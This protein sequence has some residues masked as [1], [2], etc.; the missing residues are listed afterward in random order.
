MPAISA[1]FWLPQVTTNTCLDVL[2][3]SWSNKP[4]FK[5]RS[6]STDTCLD[7]LDVPQL[8]LHLAAVSPA[9]CTIR[10]QNHALVAMP[11]L[12][13]PM[14]PA[15][16]SQVHSASEHPPSWRRKVLC[17]WSLTESACGGQHGPTNVGV[18]LAMSAIAG[19]V[20]YLKRI[21][22]GSSEEMT[23]IAREMQGKQRGTK[24]NCKK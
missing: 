22:P 2:D 14:C 8:L 4:R 16:Q 11:S 19:R 3:T 24:G 6:K 18:T 7:V 10:G 21:A 13:Q 23:G 9:V 12:P 17:I 20:G 5:N 1:T 15:A